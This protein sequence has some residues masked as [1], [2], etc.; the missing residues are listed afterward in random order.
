MCTQK[1]YCDCADNTALL[2]TNKDEKVLIESAQAAQQKA[3][4]WFSSDK[5]LAHPDKTHLLI[6]GF[7]QTQSVKLLRNYI[8]IQN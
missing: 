7:S 5:L 6:L 2:V 8:L 3:C 1:L 4:D